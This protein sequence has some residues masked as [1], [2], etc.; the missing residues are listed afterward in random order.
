M[1]GIES[2]QR[3]EQGIGVIAL[4]GEL[5]VEGIPTLDEAVQTARDAGALHLL[6]DLRRLAFMDSASA[7]AFLR[8]RGDQNEREGRLILFGLQRMV[9]RLIDAAGLASQFDLAADEEAA[10]FQLAGV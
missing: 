6:F 8:V 7:G 3:V 10:R 2:E 4:I 5:R 9:A 1:S